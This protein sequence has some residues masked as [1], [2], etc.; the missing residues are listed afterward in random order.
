MQAEDIADAIVYV[1]T[2][3]RHVAINEDPDPP[4]R[5]GT[6]IPAAA[7]ASV[8]TAERHGPDGFEARAQQATGML[9]RIV[10]TALV[11]IVLVALCWR[12]MG[13]ARRLGR[14]NPASTPAPSVPRTPVLRSTPAESR[15]TAG[16]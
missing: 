7:A 6:L 2:R 14:A 5:T 15:S 16:Y 9:K 4:D 13:A 1:V 8:V 12:G 11:V 3:P 10:P